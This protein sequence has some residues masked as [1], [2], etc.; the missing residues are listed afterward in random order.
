[1]KEVQTKPKWNE[2]VQCVVSS[3]ST[4]WIMSLVAKEKKELKMKRVKSDTKNYSDTVCAMSGFPA[5]RR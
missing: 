4:N 1:M 5:L 3:C 2:P